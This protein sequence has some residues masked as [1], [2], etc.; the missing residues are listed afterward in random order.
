MRE[1]QAVQHGQITL[2][3][4][5]R[6]RLLAA[7]IRFFLTAALCAARCPLD[8]ILVFHYNKIYCR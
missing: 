8:N 2:G 4:E 5:Q 7:G 1:G 3:K 6:A